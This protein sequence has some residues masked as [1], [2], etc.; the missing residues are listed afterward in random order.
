MLLVTA[1]LIALIALFSFLFEIY[2]FKQPVMPTYS[3]TANVMLYHD[4]MYSYAFG[5]LLESATTPYLINTSPPY[6]DNIGY[7][8]MGDYQSQIL[9]DSATNVNYLVTSF[10]LINNSSSF[11]TKVINAVAQKLQQPTSGF[12]QNYQVKIIL[13]NN[14]CSAT[15]LN[16]GLNADGNNVIES[17]IFSPIFY[18]LCQTAESSPPNI[19]TNV[20]MEP[21]Q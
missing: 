7:T 18:R 10:N 11:A 17:N 12:N 3:A 2:Y 19:K 21:L 4:A 8:A 13:T 1:P 15:I 5:N 20:I 16:Q 6:F 9:S 14:N